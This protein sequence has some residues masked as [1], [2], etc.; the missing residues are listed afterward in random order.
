MMSTGRFPAREA[1]PLKPTDVPAVQ[2][3]QRKHKGL[4]HQGDGDAFCQAATAPLELGKQVLQGSHRPVQRPPSPV[5]CG[6]PER[7]LTPLLA[8]SRTR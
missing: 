4:K 8:N 5:G 2:V 7:P 1:H 3:G 6:S